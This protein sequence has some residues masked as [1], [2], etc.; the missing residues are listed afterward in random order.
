M[1]IFISTI[2]GYRWH[3]VA[4]LILTFIFSGFG[5][6][7]LA[8]INNKLMKATEQKELL[9]WTFIG[10]LI[11]FLITSVIAQISLTALGHKFVYLMRKQLVKQLLDTGTEQLNQIGKARLLASLSGDIRNITFAF[12]RL[13][14]LVQGSILV[15]CAGAYM[16]YLSESLFFVTALWLSVTVWVSNIAVRRVYHHLRIVRETED[17][18]YKNYQSAIEGHK[19]LSLNRERAKFYFE[20][21]LEESASTQRDNSVRA[22]SYH[23]FANNWTNV[24]VL[25]AVGLVFYLSLAEGWSNL[26]TA[27]TIALTILFLRTPLISAVG[28]LPMLLN[29][30]V[31]LDKLSKLNLAPY[32]EDFA[33]SNP[34]PRDWKEIRFENVT[35]SYPTAEGTMSFALKPVNLTIKRGELIF[36]IGKNGSGKSTFSMLLAGLNHATDGK[37]FVDNIE[38]T[39]ANQR[40]FRA[41]ISAVFSDFYL[42]TQL[43]GQAGFASLKEAGQW[44]ETLQLENK[45]TVENHRLSTTNL[46]QGQRKRLGLLIALLEHRPLLILDEWAADQ[47]PTFRRT[48]Y[49]VLLPLLREKGHTVFAISHDDNYFHLADRLL[50]I[51]Q[52]ELREL[53]GEERE[54]AS[55]DAVEKLNNIIKET[56]I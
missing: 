48:F 38:I 40:A 53:F 26:E 52:G 42:F 19:E 2:K 12:V 47:D 24:M 3:L 21:E 20:R 43:L 54:T 8:F 17:K 4:V 55:H 39:A 7:V 45:V 9:I 5:I 33:I 51:S 35:Y 15:L 14:E 29:A 46:S 13:P 25:G 10:L 41:Q 1:N 11:L 49:Q 16:F 30:K 36:L 50:L 44:L 31:A 28:A 6:G 56:K 37:I 27:T 22:D 32:T 23:T 34:L 18:L